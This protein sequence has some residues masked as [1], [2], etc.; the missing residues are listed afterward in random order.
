MITKNDAAHTAVYT[1]ENSKLS[2][3]ISQLGAELVSIYDRANSRELLWQ[4]NEAIWKNQAPV[5]FPLIGRLKTKG[6]TYEGKRYDIDIH[7]FAK[8]SVFTPADRSGNSITFTLASSGETLQH[9][10]F[11]FGFSVR[12]TIDNNRLLKE[13]ITKNTSAKDMYYEAGGHEGYMLPLSGSEKMSDYFLLFKGKD[14]LYSFT[15]DDQTMML[16]QKHKFDLDNGRLYLNMGVF[17]NDAL[18]LEDDAGKVIELHGPNT[19]R[20]LTVKF[21]DFKY[22]GIWT[23]NMPSDTNYVCIEPWSSLPDF[24]HLGT[25]LTEKIGIRRLGAGQSE[26]LEYTVEVH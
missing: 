16:I 6:F 14:A 22:V 13:Y 21:S 18:V 8:T 2:V 9:Y 25:E 15:K 1:I 4:G 19:G 12:Y 3:K 26:T 10:P 24:A 11:D 23:R 7:G 20:L 17:S 5:L